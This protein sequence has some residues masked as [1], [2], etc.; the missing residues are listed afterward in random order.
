MRRLIL[1]CIG[2]GVCVY[3]NLMKECIF[4]QIVAHKIPCFKI[5]EDEHFLAFLDIH[6]WVRGHT[7]VIPKKHYRW[8]WDL[9]TDPRVSPNIGEYFAVVNRI[10]NHYRQVLRADLVMSW[11]YGLDV[12]HAHI[13]LFPS[14]QG[15]VAFYPK[16]KLPPLS[17]KEGKKLAKKLRMD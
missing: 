13:Q 1:I 11:I 10:A 4:C 14:P 2:R 3:F 5:Y 12:P 16:E 8:V 17:E 6:P 15:K 9:P 7:L